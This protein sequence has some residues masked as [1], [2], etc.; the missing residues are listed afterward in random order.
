MIG[1]LE[2]RR[3]MGISPWLLIQFAGR[4][5]ED[6]ENSSVKMNRDMGAG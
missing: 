3:S 6:G 4:G 2:R 5:R 1:K